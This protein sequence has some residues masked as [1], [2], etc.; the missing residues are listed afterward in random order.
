MSEL[1]E[2]RA[3]LAVVEAGGFGRAARRLNIAKSIV[4]RRISRL[5]A[6][7]GAPLLSRTTRGIYPTEAGL[8]F[9]A[10][11]ERVLDDLEEA[12]AAIAERSGD[13]V[14][15]L[16]LAAPLGFGVRHIAPILTELALRYPRLHIDA[17]FS[18]RIVDLVGEQFDLGVRIGRLKDSSLVARRLAPVRAAVVASPAYLAQHGT[19]ATPEDLPR[20]EC[21]VYTGST[22]DWLFHSGKRWVAVRPSGRLKSDSG[23]AILQWTVAGLGIAAL[24]TF[25]VSDAIGSGAVKP[26]LLD[27]P[28]PEFGVYT[29]RPPTAR[30]PAKV[31]VLIDTL[32]ERFAG[33]PYWD[34]CQMAAKD[35]EN[36]AGLG[37]PAAIANAAQHLTSH[38]R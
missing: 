25:A 14:G 23:E 1:D 2:I 31:R 34:P 19:P 7:L 27:H 38:S 20:H 9:K 12:R 33:E 30:V 13:V 8:E 11:A 37:K 35:H 26:L 5:E 28:M 32:V 6:G 18:D 10:R 3:F 15:R 29:V 21:I 4:S 22:S 16:R 24:P 36:A 17:E